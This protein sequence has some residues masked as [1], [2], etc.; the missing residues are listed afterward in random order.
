[1]VA[2]QPG[3]PIIPV[4]KIACEY[5]PRLSLIKRPGIIQVRIGAPIY[6]QGKTAQQV[7]EEASGWIEDRM[8]EITTL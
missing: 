8:D 7:L 6:T 4:A 5:C 2:E 3:Y 1:M